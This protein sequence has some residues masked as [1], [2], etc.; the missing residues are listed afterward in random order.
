MNL[1][2]CWGEGEDGTL[3][4]KPS[5]PRSTNDAGSMR[6]SRLDFAGALRSYPSRDEGKTPTMSASPTSSSSPEAQVGSDPL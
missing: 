2:S 4:S 5:S 6:L 1:T 3:R